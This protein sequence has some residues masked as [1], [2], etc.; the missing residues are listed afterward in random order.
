MIIL[1][2][3]VSQ[4]P[5]CASLSFWHS[6][7]ANKIVNKEEMVD[8]INSAFP[9]AFDKDPYKKLLGKLGNHGVRGKTS[10]GL[11]SC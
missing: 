11:K 4:R 1:K 10:H 2:A 7:R 8:K 9:K 3:W 6:F 5:N